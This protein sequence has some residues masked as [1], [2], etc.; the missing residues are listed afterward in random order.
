MCAPCSA[1][2]GQFTKHWSKPQYLSSTRWDHFWPLPRIAKTCAVRPKIKFRFRD[3]PIMTL[4]VAEVRNYLRVGLPAGMLETNRKQHATQIRELSPRRDICQPC[5]ILSI[6]APPVCPSNEVETLAP[7]SQ[8][9]RLRGGYVQRSNGMKWP[10]TLYL[11]NSQTS[12][13][14]NAES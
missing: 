3:G 5:D 4:W 11:P 10:N 8:T 9:E 7:Q 14:I 2:G 1:S 12:R 13:L 6:R